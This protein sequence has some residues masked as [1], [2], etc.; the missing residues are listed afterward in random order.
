VQSRIVDGEQWIAKRLAFL[1]EHLEADL[2]ESERTATEAEI[3][4]LMKAPALSCTGPN[5]G[6]L[7]RRRL[8][9]RN[10]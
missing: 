2:T 3:Q 9:R 5:G 7:L 6:G 1:R 10:R 8:R 4:R